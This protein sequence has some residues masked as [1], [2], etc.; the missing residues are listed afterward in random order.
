MQKFFVVLVS[1][2]LL[3]GSEAAVFAQAV[4]LEVRAVA[5]ETPD[6]RMPE[7]VRRGS[8]TEELAPKLRLEATVSA[9]RPAPTTATLEWYVIGRTTAE[10]VKAGRAPNTAVMMQSS[11]ES[12][13]VKPAPG[14]KTSFFAYGPGQVRNGA[15]GIGWLVRLVGADG[16]LIDARG[17]NAQIAALARDPARLAALVNASGTAKGAEDADG[18]LPLE[19]VEKI[20]A[21][22]EKNWPGNPEMQ[23]FEIKN[24]LDHHR[25][26]YRK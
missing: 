25:K 5:D 3:F 18:D 4:R 19:L 15:E 8:R 11:R 16:R 13:T 24:K 7:L 26:A 10:A 14:T 6:S 12:V 17:S 22:A 21:D 1:A 9:V 2:F 23:A 20:K